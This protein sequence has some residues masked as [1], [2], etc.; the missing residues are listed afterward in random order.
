MADGA[1]DP[2][3]VSNLVNCV[4]AISQVDGSK[5]ML[6]CVAPCTGKRGSYIS[7]DLY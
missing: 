3:G 6:I 1:R 5:R 4:S 7:S 2:S